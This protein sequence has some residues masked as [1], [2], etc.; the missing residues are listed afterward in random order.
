MHRTVCSAVGP[1]IQGYDAFILFP[2]N[3]AGPRR[4]PDLRVILAGEER[5]MPT[6]LPVKSSRG[7]GL[8]LIKGWRG[9]TMTMSALG[10]ID[11]A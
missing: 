3:K 4:I 11:A 6:S 8:G 2:V 1:P 9:P 7:I 5:S 10:W